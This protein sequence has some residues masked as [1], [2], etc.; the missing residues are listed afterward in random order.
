M[1]NVL[2]SSTRITGLG[3]FLIALSGSFSEAKVEQQQSA[4]KTTSPQRKRLHLLY[5]INDVLHHAKYHDQGE[6]DYK[7]ISSNL[8]KSAEAIIGNTAS[9]D[10]A[11]HHIQ[12]RL[13][14]L[15]DIWAANSYFESEYIQG[16]RTVCENPDKS[17]AELS[18]NGLTGEQNFN[19]SDR[20]AVAVGREVPYVMPSTHGDPSTPFY[21][22][23]AGNMIRHIVPNRQE[24]I[25]AKLMKP[26]QFAPGPADEGLANIVKDFL[27][28]TDQIY[29]NSISKS[30]N[31]AADTDEMGQSI[32]YDEMTRER[33]DD[34]Y[35]GWS[36]A[37][38][39]N[40]KKRRSKK[41]GPRRGRSLSNSIS[42]SHSRSYSRDP[43]QRR[44]RRYSDTDS[45]SNGRSRSRSYSASRSRKRT[46]RYRSREKLSR[47]R[48][49]L[50]NDSSR[51]RSLPRKHYSG[52]NYSRSRTSSRERSYSP[53]E[54]IKTSTNVQQNGMQSPYNQQFQQFQQPQQPLDPRTGLPVPSAPSLAPPT[55]N[56]FPPNLA[57]GLNGVP[58]PPPPPPASYNGIW[59]PPPP[60]L[61]GMNANL[62][63]A[64]QS[65]PFQFG[66]LPPP[67][68]PEQATNFFAQFGGQNNGLGNFPNQTPG[69]YGRPGGPG[70]Y[71]NRGR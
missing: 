39:E 12:E 23:P 27:A 29:A 46:S 26:I 28:D 2:A 54:S 66:G 56:Q 67:P 38:C 44:G 4:K 41:L 59:P 33:V 43:P 32:V 21:D 14:D 62:N 37:F 6:L 55:I 19:D 42:R 57:M 17:L 15:L 51:S 20:S 18:G 68:P 1:K 45:Q 30:D 31:L 3:K 22:L 40:M 58:F 65:M 24:P 9:S 63:N 34:T 48:R 35:Y 13:R 69:Q 8:Q 49:S 50:S 47:G 5:L 25:N 7:N 11:K 70:S 71:D 60:P 10:L 64:P 53:M 52:R 16:L 61:T 36:R